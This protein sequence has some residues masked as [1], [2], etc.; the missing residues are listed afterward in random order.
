MAFNVVICTPSIG[1]CKSAYAF[2]LA[3]LV[4]YF[5][6]HRVYPEVEEQ[7]CDFLLLE[8]SG[9]SA[10]R[11]RMT[12]MALEKPNMTHV[13]WIDE[14]MGFNLDTL[15]IMAQRRQPIVGCNYRMRVPPSEFVG[16]RKDRQGRIQTTAESTGLEEATYTGFGF[17][18]IERKVIE[19]VP[20]P[21]Y[22]IHYIP[23][24][25]SYTTEDN[26]FFI[27]AEQAGFQC[28]V[29][30]DASKRIWHCGSINYVWNEDYTNLNQ[31]FA[32]P[33]TAKSNN[34]ENKA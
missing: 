12:M 20:L 2:S 8:G 19:A 34:Q 10:N 21:R 26:P 4:A 31:N 3:R 6:Q 23:E 33:A 16:I 25:N 30:H 15:H 7:S 13:L 28:Y 14:D 17:C 22:P 24:G 9:V 5:S 27:A 11:E 29:D 1:Q 18:L 32:K